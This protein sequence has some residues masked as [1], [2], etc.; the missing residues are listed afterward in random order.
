MFIGHLLCAHT[1]LGL[2]HCGLYH[3]LWAGKGGGRGSG[4]GG[5]KNQLTPTALY[6]IT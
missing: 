2:Y 4:R 5:G 6:N 3:F 1:A